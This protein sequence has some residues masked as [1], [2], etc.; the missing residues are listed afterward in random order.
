MID[1]K[2]LR[3]ILRPGLEAM[4]SGKPLP[5]VR[6]KA[7]RGD[8]EEER[9]VHGVGRVPAGWTYHLVPLEQPLTPGD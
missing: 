8:W 4:A 6:Y 9:W 2:A 5:A 3:E 1:F 7:V